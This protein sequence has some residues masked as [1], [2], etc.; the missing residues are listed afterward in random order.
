MPRKTVSVEA[1]R[2][3]ANLLLGSDTTG[4]EQRWGVIAM[5]EFVLFETSNYKGFS[6][7]PS[8]WDEDSAALKKDYD[9]TRRKYS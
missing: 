4:V 5:I 7:L 6:Y 3:R 8:E 1:V 2:Q 9:E